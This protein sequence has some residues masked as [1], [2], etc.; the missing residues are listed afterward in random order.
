VRVINSIK[1]ILLIL[2]LGFSSAPLWAGT[3][4]KAFIESYAYKDAWI[5]LQAD[6]SDGQLK[7]RFEG[8]WCLGSLIYDRE[9]SQMTFVDDIMKTVITLTRQNQAELKLLGSIA[10]G[11]LIEGIAGATPSAKK[12]YNMV[13]VNAQ[14]FFNGTPALKK[15]SVSKGGFTCDDYQTDLD[16]KKAREVWITAPDSAGLSGEDLNTIRG[17]VH[18]VLDLCENEISHLGADTTSF[19]QNISSSTLP[20]YVDLYAGGKHSSRFEILSI[21][22][23]VVDAGSFTPPANYKNLGLLDLV[24]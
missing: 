3:E 5:N 19:Q 12:T 16:G 21:H 18:L 13:K 24:K 10:S 6:I 23:K 9:S 8:P 20:V 1:K 22:T 15:V 17:L 4:V 7:I 14:A 2:V 11:K